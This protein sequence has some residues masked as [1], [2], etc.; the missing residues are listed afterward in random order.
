MLGTPEANPEHKIII[1]IVDGLTCAE[2]ACE[3]LIHRHGDGNLK[4][5]GLAEILAGLKKVVTARVTIPMFNHVKPAPM[6]GGTAYFESPVQETIIHDTS[7][8]MGIKG[9]D[10]IVLAEESC[11]EINGDGSVAV[12][13][14]AAGQGTCAIVPDGDSGREG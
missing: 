13:A 11:S 5:S 12:N 9:D 1:E 6:M 2:G 8:L 4:F 14:E 10:K 7:A 3:Q